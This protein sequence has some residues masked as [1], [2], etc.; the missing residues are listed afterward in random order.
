M[1]Y[2]HLLTHQV[3]WI[4]RQHF[5]RSMDAQRARRRSKYA[6][7]PYL[8]K[9]RYVGLGMARDMVQRALKFHA[10]IVVWLS[11]A[12]LLRPDLLMVRGFSLL[13]HAFVHTLHITMSV[14][15]V[16]SIHDG[17]RVAFE[18]SNDADLHSINQL[19]KEELKKRLTPLVEKDVYAFCFDL[20][21]REMNKVLW[22]DRE[23]WDFRQCVWFDWGNTRRVVDMEEKADSA[24][25]WLLSWR[26]RYREKLS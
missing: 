20:A 23:T 2:D 15:Q 19:A 22:R 26:V 6:A 1:I 11:V 4:I 9:A 17:L 14:T 18:G 5:C 24:A 16:R 12:D 8:S 7:K 21:Y 10:R 13:W 3:Q 25:Q